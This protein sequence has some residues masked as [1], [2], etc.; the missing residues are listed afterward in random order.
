MRNGDF[1]IHGTGGFSGE[2]GKEGFSMKGIQGGDRLAP[3]GIAAHRAGRGVW[4]RF[5]VAGFAALVVLVFLAAPA[6]AQQGLSLGEMVVTASRVPEPEK[7]TTSAVIVIRRDDIKRM[8]VQFV[9]DVLRQVADINL[10]QSG[11][12]GRAATVMLRGGSPNQVLV[13]IDGVKVK[14]TTTGQFDF[15]GITVDDIERIE[16]VKGPQSTIYGSEAMAGVINIITRKGAPGARAEISYES[17][18]NSTTHPSFTLSGGMGSYDYRVT[19]SYL[20]TEG[21]SAAK[22]GAE[23]DG[24]RNTTVSGKFGMAA[25]RNL[26]IEVSGKYREDRADLD[27]GTSSPDDPNYV[28]EGR[29]YVFSTKGTLLLWDKWEQVL[30][31]STVRE[32]L[33]YSD[34]DPDPFS[35]YNA[36][37]ESRTDTADWQHNFYLAN[38][39]SI[40]LGAEHRRE[41]GDIKDSFDEQIDN[42]AV[43]FNT[44]RK[45]DNLTMTLGVRQ[46]MHETFGD[47]L[48]WRAGL[49][50]EAGGGMRFRASYGTGFR[51]P[52]LNELFYPGSG[53][54]D[55]KPEESESWELGVEQDYS[56]NLTLSVTYFEQ[57]YH[58]LIEWVETAPWTWQPENVSRAK[59]KGVEAGAT[60]RLS[61]A[62][63]LRAAYANLDT[64]DRTDGGR[65]PRRPKDKVNVGADYSGGRLSLHADYSYVGKR[66]DPGVSRNLAPYNLVN[67]SGD[68][69][70]TKYISLFARVEN[71]LNED[72]EEVGG[73]GTPGASLYGGAKIVF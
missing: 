71:L 34:P 30:T 29:H 41:K 45:S 16:I 46:D 32:D 56:E 4:M 14:S 3:A 10:F 54:P 6:P 69:G 61:S 55:L 47:R 52:T 23:R 17:G 60:Y 11:G 65:L 13:M 72:Y 53:N 70:L 12:V 37:I 18:A 64:E 48:T 63:T 73:Y 67:L 5:P 26:N 1:E 19:G 24:Y 58:D 57:N 50:E 21:I 44:R 62:F 66:Y 20:D 7:E 33:T 51:A 25:T 39:Y 8:N 27:F 2:M 59:V 38:G 22:G 36:E 42:T 49:T 9:P 40:T 28:Q 31:L 43:Y 68:L 35:F 15:A